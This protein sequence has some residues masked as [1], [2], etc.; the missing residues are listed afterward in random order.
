VGKRNQK[1]LDRIDLLSRI[2]M[3]R[4]STHDREVDVDEWITLP[5]FPR[6]RDAS[7]PAGCE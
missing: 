5:N 1:N 7:L 2:E 4:M 6:P 3:G